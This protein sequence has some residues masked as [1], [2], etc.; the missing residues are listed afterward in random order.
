[1]QEAAGCFSGIIGQALKVRLHMF[2]CDLLAVRL[3]VPALGLPPWGGRGGVDASEL[4]GRIFA[5]EV[6][7]CSRKGMMS[8]SSSKGGWRRLGCSMEE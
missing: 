2:L 6:Q 5:I 1:M 7:I 4:L 8:V 3:F